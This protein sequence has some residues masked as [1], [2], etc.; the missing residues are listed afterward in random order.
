MSGWLKAMQSKSFRL[1]GSGLCWL[2]E[3]LCAACW[4][5][6]EVICLERG[7]HLFRYRVR[8][9][10][11]RVAAGQLGAIHTDG[12]VNFRLAKQA[13]HEPFRISLNATAQIVTVKLP[14]DVIA[15]RGRQ[16]GN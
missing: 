5:V 15:S 10:T 16:R 8:A 1:P 12:I 3:K 14:D 7:Y 4:T 13:G 6:S 9:A 11:G 2:G